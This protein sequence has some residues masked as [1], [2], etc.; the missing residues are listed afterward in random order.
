MPSF[1][2]FLSFSFRDHSL[3][4]IENWLGKIEN[5][6][7]FINDINYENILKE[8]PEEKP[9]EEEEKKA[10]N[11][12]DDAFQNIGTF[13]PQGLLGPDDLDMRDFTKN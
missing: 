9:E 2:S 7:K 12:E 13:L 4:F 3:H 11:N 8:N 5:Y 6:A 10:D 1:F